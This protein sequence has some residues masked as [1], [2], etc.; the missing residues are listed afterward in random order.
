[1]G[2]N[3]REFLKTLALGSAGLAASG[4]DGWLRASGRTAPRP[5]ASLVSLRAG[6]DR[7][8]L[9]PE[10]LSPLRDRLRAELRNRPVLIKPNLV[11]SQCPAGVTHA[12]SVRALI[13][14]LRDLTDAPI[15]IG[16]SPASGDAPKCFERYGYGPLAKDLGVALVDLNARPVREVDGMGLAGGGTSGV[17]MIAD[18]LDPGP[19][20]VSI[21]RP[22][23]HDN[24]V[25]TLTLKNLVMAAPVVRPGASDKLVMHGNVS[26]DPLYAEI[27]T[28][29][30]FAVSDR[31][32][33]D[34]AILD[35]VEGMEGNGPCG[36]P[37]VRHGFAAAGFDAIAVDSVGARLMGI[38]PRHLPYLRWCGDAGLGAFDAAAISIDGPDP[39]GLVRRYKPHEFFEREI[40]WIEKAGDRGPVPP[41]PLF[42]AG[43]AV[44]FRDREE[45]RV[46]LAFPAAVE[47]RLEVL[48]PRGR[49]ICRLVDERVEPGRRALAWDGRDGWGFRVRPGSYALRLRAGRHEAAREVVVG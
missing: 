15:S 11:L 29:N 13:G 44:S 2:A 42:R 32:R 31:L 10:V 8:A 6:F 28:R 1:M 33:P 21:C 9:I 46:L 23:T 45:S 38:D 35:G 17:R 37:A 36:G 47:A 30:M 41:A 48:D 5:A 19:F 12:D 43:G 25:A 3:R 39:G 7:S 49:V 16:E 24:V 26:T 22:K 40:L 4:W 20:I 34:L 14:V 27:L 18:L